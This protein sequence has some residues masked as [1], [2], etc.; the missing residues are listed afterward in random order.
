MQIGLLLTGLLCASVALSQTAVKWGAW[1]PGLSS[2][3]SRGTKG[4]RGGP[5]G[6]FLTD[7]PAH[8]YDVILGRPTRDSV[9]VSLLSYQKAKGQIQYGAK[10]GVYTHETPILVLEPGVPAE[11]PLTGLLPN[12]RHYYRVR[13]QTNSTGKPQDG[14]ERT[15]HTQRPAGSPFTFTVQADS[16][17]DEN[18]DPRIYAQTLRNVQADAPDFHIDLGDTFMTGKY[19]AR[20][21]DALAQYLAQRY[22][23]GLVC[24][25]AALF[26]VLG[27]H[28]GETGGRTTAAIR[29]RARHFPNPFPDS[30]YT[31]CQEQI[32]GVG[33]TQNTYSWEWGDALFIV[34]DP[35]RHTAPERGRHK[36]DNWG[37][38]LGK[39]QYDWLKALLE[40]SKARFRFVFIHHL[41]GG[42]D[43]NAR[44]GAEAATLY[45]WGGHDPDGTNTFQRHR[46]GWPMPIHRLLVENRVNVVFHGHDH[47]FAH[48]ELDGITYQLVPQPGHASVRPPRYAAEYGYRTGNILG[49]SGHLRVQVGKDQ[50]KIDYILSR[51]ASSR[52][53]AKNGDIA[54]SYRVTPSAAAR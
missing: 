28:D 35:F 5:T 50:T 54:F 48:Q 53:A 41:V 3:S 16:H 44:G 47:F 49:G 4:S 39:A 19:G 7:V 46:P 11:I 2:T 24:H 33:P 17:L 45:E 40:Q 20:H 8:A 26:L 30:F 23:F 25:S 36:A 27:N 42:L 14:P 9:T 34:L 10:P 51:L 29:M 15:F 43:R 21:E 32:K 22:Y 52:S 13:C 38:T 18:T 6:D 31:G 37:R 1:K 12:A